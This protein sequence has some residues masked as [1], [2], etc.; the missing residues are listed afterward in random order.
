[1]VVP[2]FVHQLLQQAEEQKLD[3][4]VFDYQ[5]LTE[6]E[7]Q[8]PKMYDVKNSDV[9]SGVDIADVAFEGGLV[10]NM[11]FPW[12][13]LLRRE[14]LEEN[15]IVFP[16]GMAY[17]EDTAWMAKVVLLADKIQ[18]SSICAYMYWHHETS[19]CGQLNKYYPGKTIYERCIKTPETLFVLADELRKRDVHLMTKYAV[20]LENYAIS[21]YLNSL[22]IMLGR[23]TYGER[24]SFYDCMQLNE[25]NHLLINRAANL[26]QIMLIPHIGMAVAELFAVIYKMTHIKK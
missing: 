17:G 24:K 19:I 26:T 6:E 8:I 15:N 22:P 20:A 11:G 9:M 5:D 3:V 16:V 1:M 2:T 18:S 10:N 4:L 14:Y 21:H 23:T 7:Q 12:R 25:Y 13:F